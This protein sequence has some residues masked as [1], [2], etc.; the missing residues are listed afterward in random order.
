MN[1]HPYKNLPDSAFWRE[2][3]SLRNPTD[4]AEIYQPK[5]QI[6]QNQKIATAGSCF[7]QHFSK[8]LKKRKCIFLD[9]EPAPD[10]L[11]EALRRQ[12]NYGIYSARYANIYTARQM[13]QTL[14][15]AIGEFDPIDDAWVKADTLQ[16]P[17][18]P[19]IEPEGYENRHELDDARMS[20]LAA[21]RRVFGSARVFVLTLGL[22]EAWENTK[23]GLVYP[24][25]PGTVGGEFDQSQHKFRNFTFREIYDDLSTFFKAARLL[26]PGMRFLLTVSPVPLTAT[27]S[28][29][30][31]L[32][33]TIRSK[34]T[35][36]AVCAE[37][38]DA[39]DYVDYFPSY[40]LISSH[41][42]KGF[43]FEP[44]MRAVSKAGVDFAMNTFFDAHGIQTE[45][46]EPCDADGVDE[47]DIQCEEEILKGFAK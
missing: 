43:F 24:M 18:R 37:L 17:L 13:R 46:P 47:I 38:V 41:P 5:F 34:S 14:D 7:A 9:E 32:S 28:G 21:I 26:R 39:Y 20:H 8:A 15:R 23:D 33:A 44:D 25:C 3:V 22:T 6:R 16:D 29:E 27:A 4:I 19:L 45:E 40:E 35:L 31:V 11:P 12:F 2:A 1:D 36:R 30:H 10:I 42:F